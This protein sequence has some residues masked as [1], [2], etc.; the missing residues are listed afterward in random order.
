MKERRSTYLIEPRLQ[1]PLVGLVAAAFVISGL[2]FG[3][4]IYA[5]FY[6]LDLLVQ[7]VGGTAGIWWFNLYYGGLITGAFLFSGIGLCLY[8]LMVTNRLIGP[9]YRIKN[10]LEKI[11]ENGNFK[12]L[13]IREEDFPHQLVYEINN[14]LKLMEEL[15]TPGAGPSEKD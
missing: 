9:L 15:P 11:Q 6:Q 5:L 10:Q 2:L 12:P 1:L 14:T 7:K 13:T 4:W 3:S 8:T